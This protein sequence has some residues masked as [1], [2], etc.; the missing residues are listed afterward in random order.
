MSILKKLLGLA[1]ER[2]ADPST[3]HTESVRRIVGRLEQLE[4]E[5][6]RFVAAFAYILGRVAHADLE[7]S[8]AESRAMEALVQEHGGLAEDQA[9]LVVEIAK[10]Q[11]RLFGGTENF[12]VTREFR[13]IASREER[14]QL[15][16]CL[17]AVSAA[18]DAVSI[19]EE[20]QVRRIASELGLTHQEYVEVR[21]R[22]SGMRDVM[23]DFRERS[24]HREEGD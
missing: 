10:S 7:I 9:L 21:A 20:E 4:P 17:F 3:S 19:V 14:L 22:Y 15:L 1:G 13:E 11:N 6:A 16:D 12:L 2:S 24:S 18:D 23:R 8:Q 5:R